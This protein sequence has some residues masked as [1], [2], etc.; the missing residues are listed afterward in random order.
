[1]SHSSN[2]SESILPAIAKQERELLARIRSSEEEAQS[3]L[4]KTRAD[5]REYR[6]EREASLADEVAR[7]RREAEEVRLGE[8]QATVSAAEEKLVEVRETALL[9]VPEMAKEVLALFLPKASGGT[10]S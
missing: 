6:Q 7:I 9:R 10:Q 1:M 2:V 8:F 4:E 3:I 5:A